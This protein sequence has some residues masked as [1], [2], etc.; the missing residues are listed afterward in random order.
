MVLFTGDTIP[1]FNAKKMDC[2]EFKNEEGKLEAKGCFIKTQNGEW[3][4]HGVWLFYGKKEILVDSI[5][6]SFGRKIGTRKMF[7]KKGRE[8]AIIEYHGE[9]YPRTVKAI[10]FFTSGATR[11]LIGNFIEAS[12][13]SLTKHGSFR[14]IRANGNLIDSV[15]YT[16]GVKQYRTSFYPDGK[17]RATYDYGKNPKQ[18]SP[19]I[20]KI[21]NKNGRL[22]SSRTEYVGE[23]YNID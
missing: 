3:E 19:V 23:E 22:R 11:I 14:Y 8:K 9:E 16:N 10:D 15:Y 17:I 5:T 18:G 1:L 6:F 2:K 7:D 4:K 13:D 21:Y 20:I 12:A